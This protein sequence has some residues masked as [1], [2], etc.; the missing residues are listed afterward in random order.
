[1]VS[2]STETY[3]NSTA[4]IPEFVLLGFPGLP[5][6]YYGLLAV[7][8]FF[9]YL[10]LAS[11]NIF[12]IVF[13]ACEKSL[14]KPTYI[15]FC[16]LAIADLGFG[17]TTVP[18]I[19]SRYWMSDKIISFNA[20]FTQMYF[21]HFF[22]SSGS[23]FMAL[24]AL[25][26]FVAICN[27]LRYPALIKNSTIAIFCS[28][29]WIANLIS[30]G[31]LTAQA[32]SVI[33]CGPNIIAQ[34]YCDY[35]SL[36]KLACADITTIKATSIAVAMSVLWGLLFFIIFS[37][38]SIII[39]VMKILSKEGQYKTFSTCTPQLFIIC[40]YYLPRT[41]V[42]MAHT[43]SFDLGIDI[44]IMLTMMYSLFPALINP[45]IYCFKTREFKEVLMKKLK[46]RQAEVDGKLTLT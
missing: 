26:R 6:Q 44:H 41:F 22:A 10:V 30:F 34:C 8:F 15:I 5:P 32:L 11:G 16:N 13:V 25:D 2:G 4:N 45:F 29:V 31:A 12:I 18:R 17:T 38:I 39:S 36:T 28:V 21:V 37:Y 19:I 40:L 14:Q 1:M 9:I 42:Y 46:Q 7:V 23:F 33:Y 35:I 3:T 24:M 43:L 20:C 27:P